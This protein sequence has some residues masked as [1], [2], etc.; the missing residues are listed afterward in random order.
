MAAWQYSRPDL[1]KAVVQVF[2]RSKAETPSEGYRLQPRGLEPKAIYTVTDVDKPSVPSRMS[3][4]ELMKGGLVVSFPQK[5]QSAL[6][7]LQKD[8]AGSG[9]DKKR[10]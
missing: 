1:G 9:T 7:I 3:G 2:R 10:N 6:F 8:S 5:P 4:E